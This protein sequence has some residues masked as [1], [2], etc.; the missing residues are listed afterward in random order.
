M[1][2]CTNCLNTCTTEPKQPVT[3]VPPTQVC[4]NICGGGGGESMSITTTTPEWLEITNDS[5]GNYT[6]N[7]VGEGAPEIY[8]A[9]HFV[10][11][12]TNFDITWEDDNT[13]FNFP[14]GEYKILYK[15]D[16]VDVSADPNTSWIYNDNAI[17]YV[18][19][20]ANLIRVQEIDNLPSGSI[21]VGCLNTIRQINA[22]SLFGLDNYYSPQDQVDPHGRFLTKPLDFT[23]LWNSATNWSIKPGNYNISDGTNELISYTHSATNN[24]WV[25]GAVIAWNPNVGGENGS[26]GTD[27]IDRLPDGCVIIGSCGKIN[28]FNA[29]TLFGIDTFIYDTTPP[30]EFNRIGMVVRAPENFRVTWNSPTQFVIYGTSFAVTR[31]DNT[32]ISFTT[33]DEKEFS[34]NTINVLSINTTDPNNIYIMSATPANTPEDAVI[35][36]SHI[37]I[38]GVNT[39]VINGAGVFPYG[40]SSGNIGIDVT[41]ATIDGGR[42]YHTDILSAP[43][44]FKL[45][46]TGTSAFTITKGL[47]KIIDTSSKK[48]LDVNIT[49]DQN[50]IFGTSYYL[51]MLDGTAG[52]TPAIQA[53]MLDNL[54]QQTG[55]KI[56]V[57]GTMNRI[58]NVNTITLF[59]LGNFPYS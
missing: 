50:I 1:T 49:T 56:H 12:P 52:T 3:P 43:V 47:Y 45:T 54:S 31:A 6:I 23:F 51:Y 42:A 5:A 44:D 22:I 27:T 32:V 37:T 57:I 26:I 39:I 20:D 4:I 59:G 10:N 36:G 46:W 48:T 41:S 24:T 40:E 19:P 28:G 8:P 35:I 15:G 18:D 38:D 55:T 53:G 17:V 30:V 33:T 2:I 11:I 25:D 13:R 16:F 21:V 34:F 58:N 7:Y 9:A 14:D 29:V